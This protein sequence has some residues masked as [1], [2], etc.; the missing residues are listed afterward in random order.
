[1]GLVQHSPF[2]YIDPMHPHMYT[3]HR[4]PKD[5]AVVK[6]LFVTL[7]KVFSDAQWAGPDGAKRVADQKVSCLL[8]QNV[9]LLQCMV[10]M[11]CH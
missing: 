3:C 6:R 5:D 10:G 4:P 7:E 11:A 1:M 9:A 8:H 2:V